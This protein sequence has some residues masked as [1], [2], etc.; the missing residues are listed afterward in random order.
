M[1][2]NDKTVA[3]FLWLFSLFYFSQCWLEEE[4]L[5]ISVCNKDPVIVGSLDHLLRSQLVVCMSWII[6]FG[7]GGGEEQPKKNTTTTVCNGLSKPIAVGNRIV[8]RLFAVSSFKLYTSHV[9][10]RFF[11]KVGLVGG[12]I[13]LKIV[14][15]RVLSVMQ[16]FT[17]N[18]FWALHRRFQCWT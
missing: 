6:A 12:I 16:E 8:S 14:V 13:F 7:I 9:N 15:N 5:E 17:Y 10:E 3:A 18:W 11:F 1:N 4:V 2:T